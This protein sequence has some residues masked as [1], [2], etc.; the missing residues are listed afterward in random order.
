MVMISKKSIL[1]GTVSSVAAVT[2]AYS[3]DLRA[4]VYKAPP[5]PVITPSWTGFYLGVHGGAAWQRADTSA[6]QYLGGDFGNVAPYSL[7]T[8]D[9]GFLGGV[10]AGYNWQRDNVVFGIEADWS[11]LSGSGSH[12]DGVIFAEN[13]IDWLGTA[14]VRLGLTFDRTL[15]YVTGGF[16]YGKVKNATGDVDVVAE[17]DGNVWEVNKTRF[18][19]AVGGGLEH[20]FTPNWTFR[21][22]GL[23]VDLGNTH[24]DVNTFGVNTFEESGAR[25]SFS[26]E[27]VLVRGAINYKF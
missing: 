17:S 26:N 24:Q 18:G 25:A 16:A 3:A 15:L 12:D 8:K 2:V 1:L 14:R 20:M 4:P 11:K 21:V 23:F 13:K 19:Y 6:D 5:A 7:S 22:E 9:T 10:Q 27:V